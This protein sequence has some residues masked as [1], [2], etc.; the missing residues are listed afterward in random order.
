MSGGGLHLQWKGKVRMPMEGLKLGQQVSY[1]QAPAC[2]DPVGEATSYW[3]Q[4]TQGPQRQPPETPGTHLKALRFQV[5]V[6][7]L[8]FVRLE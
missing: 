8:L 5:I 6:A 2:A 7:H 1:Q 4:N 3:P